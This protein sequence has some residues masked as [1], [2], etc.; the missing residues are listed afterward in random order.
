MVVGSSRRIA[1]LVPATDITMGA[2]FGIRW[3]RFAL[4]AGFLEARFDMAE[5]GRVVGDS[6]SF[7]C[8][9]DRGRYNAHEFGSLTLHGSE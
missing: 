9:V 5:V 4:I 6:V 8:E 2:R 7:F 1:F 3:S